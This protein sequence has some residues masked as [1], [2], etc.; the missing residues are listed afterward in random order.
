MAGP[1]KRKRHVAYPRPPGGGDYLLH[2]PDALD[3]HYVVEGREDLFN[4]GTYHDMAMTDRNRLKEKIEKL[5][6]L[7]EAVASVYGE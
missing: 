1:H 3:L 2:V 6:K 5:K 4:G 7:I